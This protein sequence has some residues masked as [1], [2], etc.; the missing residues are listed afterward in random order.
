[1]LPPNERVKL[2]LAHQVPDRVP[3]AL[4]GGPYGLVDPLYLSLLE[5]LEIAAPANPIRSGHTV[6][7]LDDR[8]L[9]ALGTDTRYIWPGDSP[10][11][12]KYSSNN[13][14]LVYDDFGQP[15][16]RTSPYFSATEGLLKGATSINEI[17]DNVQWPNPEDPRWTKGVTKR[18]QSINDSGYYIIGRM[19][20]SHGPF[21]MACDLR[22]MEN[23][24]VDLVDRPDFA[25]SLLSKITELTC[26]LMV[27]YLES[28]Q[29]VIDMIELPGDD[30]A[31][32][33]NLVISPK[34]FQKMIRPYLEK[35]ILTIRK[36]QPEAKIM[37]HS[38]GAI[39]KLVPDF[40]EMGVDV[41]HPLE[42][43]VGM[44]PAIIKSKYGK[45]ICFLGG[46]DISHALPG[47]LDDVRMDIDRCIKDLSPGGGYIMAPCNH[48]QADIPPQ[49][50]IE[51][52][53]YAKE[54]GIYKQ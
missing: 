37:L 29:G 21:Q 42:P 15:W 18:A 7:Y 1:M 40:I 12:P 43:V 4:W 11:S 32:N 26:R 13:D 50:V 39:G 30:Y 5:K 36:Q 33:H 51:M 31:G 2:S 47:S 46:V 17:E 34:L 45:Q 24:L 22:G 19:V 38:D 20:L 16:Q 49:N 25:H 9:D 52:Y 28:A 44:N 35:M 14:E 53:S 23:F 48:L 3:L 10:S 41:L 8:I 54:V 27:N 6:N